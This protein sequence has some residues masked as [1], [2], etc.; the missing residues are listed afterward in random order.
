MDTHVRVLGILN[1]IFGTLSAIFGVTIFSIFGG[2][3][4]MYAAAQVDFWMA[5]LLA[6]VLFHSAVAVPC[7]ALGVAVM[8]Y[9]DAAKSMM[10]VT[11][12]LNLLNVPF[13]PFVG[14]YGLWVLLSPETDPLFSE[15]PGR[16]AKRKRPNAGGAEPE[17]AGIPKLKRTSILRSS[18]ADAGPQ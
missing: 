13:G 1:I 10:I 6:I 9:S 16:T 11:S 12:A 8:Q 15:P 4:E 17:E 3:P 7:I 18:G 14:G 2:I 5:A